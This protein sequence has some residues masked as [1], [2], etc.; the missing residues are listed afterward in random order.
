MG[1]TE[2]RAWWS[3]QFP[4][5]PPVGFMLR[6][7]Y[8]ERWLRIHSLPGSK[9]YGETEEEYAELLLR[10]NAVATETLTEGSA[11]YLIQGFWVETHEE[12][13]GWVVTLEGE[14]QNRRFEV[15]ETIWKHSQHDAL[16]REVADWKT[17]NVV[18]ASRE[19]GRLYA[20][21]DGGADLIFRNAQERDELKRVY[22]A[23]LS[24]HPE[25][26]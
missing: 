16:L 19:S 10:H 9:R 24:A 7:I 6:Q 12:Q 4:D 25:G 18:F 13:G 8:P 5:S 23:W 20:P 15:T 14:E 2:Y 11:C 21:Y 26:L 3:E 22:G 17:A 1:E